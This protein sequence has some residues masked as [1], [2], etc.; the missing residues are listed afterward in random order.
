MPNHGGANWGVNVSNIQHKLS[1]NHYSKINKYLPLNSSRGR[2]WG[3]RCK[4]AFPCEKRWLKSQL[5]ENKKIKKRTESN[6]NVQ[7]DGRS[8]CCSSGLTAAAAALLQLGAPALSFSCAGEII[9]PLGAPALPTR[10]VTHPHHLHH[11]RTGSRV[12]GNGRGRTKRRVSPEPVCMLLRCLSA[13]AHTTRPEQHAGWEISTDW[14]VTT[15]RL[16]YFPGSKSNW[17]N[18]S[19]TKLV[20][21]VWRS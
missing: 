1:H 7:F 8:L 21:K 17:N 4:V 5:G 11:S 20:R 2:K 10:S 3:Y 13:C 12:G 16:L 18:P 19:T 6:V 15:A 9:L 14:A